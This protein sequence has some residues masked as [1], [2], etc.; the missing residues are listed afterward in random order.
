MAY[1][2]CVLKQGACLFAIQHQAHAQ[3]R[4]A[5]EICSEMNL[6]RPLRSEARARD[7]LNSTLN[8]LA[9]L[10]L[11]RDAGVWGGANQGASVKLYRV[12]PGN[13]LVIMGVVVA[14]ALL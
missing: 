8:C 12:T 9:L 4:I 5:L 10:G 2:Q 7:L 1:I 6:R 11:V 13:S 14:C 3:E